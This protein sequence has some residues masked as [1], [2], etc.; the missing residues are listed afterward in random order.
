[1]D[2]KKLNPPP[3]VLALGATFLLLSCFF[4]TTKG[5]I[6][7]QAETEVSIWILLFAQGFVALI[8]SL[9]LSIYKRRDILRFTAWKYLIART[10]LSIV[11][12]GAIFVA[13]AH[14]K[15][16]NVFLLMNTSPIFIPIIA[17]FWLKTKIPKIMWASIFVGF[18]GILS[19]LRPDM[20]LFHHPL[21][22][23]ALLAGVLFSCSQILVRIMVDL[24]ET[25]YAILFL[26]FA[27]FSLITLPGAI[28][29]WAP[30][31]TSFYGLLIATGA[32]AF[33]QQFC[34]FQAFSRAHPVQIGPLNYSSVVFAYLIGW[35]FWQQK[36]DW[37]GAIGIVLVIIGGLSAIYIDKKTHFNPDS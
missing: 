29:H 20:T 13:V 3:L 25:P 21:I 17:S 9:P 32:C 15:L 28:I 23:I 27:L 5:A 26:Y 34:L 12:I 33:I 37:L 22:L 36:L 31:P 18:V 35:I 4:A 19:I 10:L 6:V 2:K 7:K 24:G 1:M 11:A 14:V 30:I 8:C 16:V